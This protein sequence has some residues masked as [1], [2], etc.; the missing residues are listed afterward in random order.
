[1]GGD[2]PPEDVLRRFLTAMQH[3]RFDEVYDLVSTDLKANPT[4]GK[5]RPRESWIRE[6]PY[7]LNFHPTKTFE[8]M[9]LAGEDEAERAQIPTLFVWEDKFLHHLAFEQCELYTL[10][11]KPERVSQRASGL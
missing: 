5:T 9:L 11:R 6:A 1:M 7:L 4:T 10:V 8:F 2:I 3:Q